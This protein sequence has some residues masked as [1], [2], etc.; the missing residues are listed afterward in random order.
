MRE[1]A[2][3]GPASAVVAAVAATLLMSACSGDSGGDDGVSALPP[4]D[5][6]TTSTTVTAPPCAEARHLVVFDTAGT[7]TATKEEV[8]EWLRDPTDV[9]AP[10]PL[11]AELANAYHDRG[12]ELLYVS[13]LPGTNTIGDVAVPDAL[14]QWLLDNGFPVDGARVETSHTPDPS[15]ELSSDLVALASEGVSI[16]VGYTDHPDD[17]ESFRV[18]GVAE[19]YL[20]GGPATSGVGSTSLP[21]NDLTPQLAKVEA[22]PPVCTP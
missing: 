2:I 18:G 9:P 8:L 19:I 6:G 5:G 16:D 12:Y 21:D 1:R 17:V 14:M 13:G 11:A 10:R 15:L 22:L 4:G 3:G 7:I 20:L